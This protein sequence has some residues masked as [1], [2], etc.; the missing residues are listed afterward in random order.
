V[1]SASREAGVPAVAVCG[2]NRLT[3]AQVR[4]LGLERVY[5]LSDLESDVRRSMSNAA[6]LL[7]ETCGRIAGDW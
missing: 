6:A 7:A 3:P 4:D 1:A 2:A 5:A